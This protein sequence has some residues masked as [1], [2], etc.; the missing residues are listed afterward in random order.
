MIIFII[1]NQW[2]VTMYGRI[3]QHLLKELQAIK[4]AG[5]YKDERMVFLAI[6]RLSKPLIIP[7]RNGVMAS[8]RSALSAA[9]RKFI[10]S[11]KE[12]SPIF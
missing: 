6:P 9:R 12:K 3:K 4:E 10:N 11:W 7:W 2:E 1:N 8:A 5:L